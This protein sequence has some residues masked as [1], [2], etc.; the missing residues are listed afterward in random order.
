[1]QEQA[2]DAVP[3][4]DLRSEVHQPRHPCLIEDAQAWTPFL[5]PGIKCLMQAAR[6]Q[7]S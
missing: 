1:M 7:L 3:E 4:D 2:S 6:S 5:L